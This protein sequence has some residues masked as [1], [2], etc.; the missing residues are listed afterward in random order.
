MNFEVPRSSGR[1]LWIMFFAVIFKLK[2]LMLETALLVPGYSKCSG[3]YRV[4]RRPCS[5]QDTAS[6]MAYTECKVRKSSKSLYSQL[7]WL[8]FDFC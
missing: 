2:L 4:W 8:K 5:F 1:K 6:V 7:Y 3:L